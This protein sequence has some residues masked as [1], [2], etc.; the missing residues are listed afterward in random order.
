ML[1]LSC[2]AHSGDANGRVFI[3]ENGVIV[4]TYELDSSGKMAVSTTADASGTTS[5]RE[6]AYDSTGQLQ[7]VSR[8]EGGVRVST[9]YL[10]RP[11][12]AGAG[13]SS[14][15][16]AKSMVSEDGTETKLATTYYYG[17]DGKLDGMLQTDSAGNV[18]SKSSED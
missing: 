10:S 3:R 9:T 12:P 7:S 1:A 2:A 11:I 4:T 13:S 17:A 18:E 5:V 15:S 8:V 6:Y 16:A 14:A